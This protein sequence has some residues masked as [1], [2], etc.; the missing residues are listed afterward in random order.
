MEKIVQIFIGLIVEIV[1]NFIK[2]ERGNKMDY[3]KTAIMYMILKT[4]E[5]IPNQVLLQASEEDYMNLL[6]EY[7]DI[8]NE[9][10][11][12]EYVEEFL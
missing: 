3:Y 6:T 8:N 2:E 12:K 10:E 1:I 4:S 11:L 7:L 5:R 9:Y